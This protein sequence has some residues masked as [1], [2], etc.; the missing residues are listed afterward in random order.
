[1]AIPPGKVCTYGQITRMAR[2]GKNYRLIG[3]ALHNLPADS[4]IPW[5]RVVNHFGRISY[6][7]SRRGHDFLQKILLEQEGI[8]FDKDDKIDLHKFGYKKRGLR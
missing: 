8:V 7:P 3:Y 4:N 2:L 1:M 6:S 5:Q